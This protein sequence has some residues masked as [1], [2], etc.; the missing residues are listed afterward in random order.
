MAA[1]AGQWHG[2]P[3]Q[4]RHRAWVC[5]RNG[6]VPARPSRHDP[7][8]R[9]RCGELRLQNCRWLHKPM[10][11]FRQI[12]VNRNN[13]LRSTGPKTEAGKRRSRRNAVRHGLTAETVVVALEDIEDYQAFRRAQKT[14]IRAHVKHRRSF[15]ETPLPLLES[16]QRP[17]EIDSSKRWPIH[18]CEIELAEHTLP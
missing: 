18:V 5:N 2:H 6:S 4:R 17:Q 13:A 8:S 11:S 9:H 15:S 16:A 12:K 1:H 10:T 14:D 3:D 7:W